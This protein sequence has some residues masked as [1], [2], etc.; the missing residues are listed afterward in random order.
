MCFRLSSSVDPRCLFLLGRG[1][2]IVSILTA[3][4]C[5]PCF[6]WPDADKGRVPRLGSL[7]ALVL[8]PKMDMLSRGRRVGI[9]P[10]QMPI[11]SSTTDHSPIW[12]VLNMNSAWS[13][14]SVRYRRRTMVAQ[15]ALV[16]G[17][18]LWACGVDKGVYDKEYS[19]SSEA[20]HQDNG[21]LDSPSH[22]ERDQ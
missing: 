1:D 7:L 18:A 13:L 21:D 15:L 11:P 9:D 8:P 4:L 20:K 6:R 14:Y 19:Q 5:S 3:S 2:R 17:S 10:A 16:K 12:P 22:L